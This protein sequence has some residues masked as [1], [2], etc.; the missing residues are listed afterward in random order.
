MHAATIPATGLQIIRRMLAGEPVEQANSGLSA[1]E[2]REL[3]AMLG[4]E[5]G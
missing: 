5:T 2:W 1:R 3:M 4:Q